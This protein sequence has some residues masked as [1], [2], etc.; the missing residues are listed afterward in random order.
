MNNPSDCNRAALTPCQEC[1]WR[2]S[3]TGRPAPAP[4]EDSFTTAHH[5]RCWRDFINGQLSIC[6]LTSPDRE[7]FPP[8]NHPAWIEAGYKAV[9]DHAKPRECAGSVAA[10]LR[11]V[12]TL[13]DAG[14]FEKYKTERPNGMTLETARHWIARVAGQQTDWP[15]LR[16]PRIDPTDVVDPGILDLGWLDLVPVESKREF[17]DFLDSL[18]EG[19]RQDGA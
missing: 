3:N 14:S 2:A 13:I 18:L 9:P 19:A 1:P 4:F 15:D 11:E 7:A 8:G 16:E 10:A 12:R 5:L 17:S 6:H